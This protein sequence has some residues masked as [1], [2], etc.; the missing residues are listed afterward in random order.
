MRIVSLVF[1]LT[2]IA[3]PVVGQT[4]MSGIGTQDCKGL[5]SNVRAGSGFMENQVS[6]SAMS[7]VQG[8]ISGI[9]VMKLQL[10]K[11][12]FDLASISVDEQWA[13]VAA[14]CRSNPTKSIDHAVD[15]LIWKRLVVKPLIK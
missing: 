7:W 4:A 6:M 9:N 13:F 14:Y 8:F 2:L 12:F 5:N 15:D 10:E 3:S 11:K 1:V